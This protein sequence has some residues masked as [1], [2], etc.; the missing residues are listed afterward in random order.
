M[1]AIAF[2]KVFLSIAHN[3]QIPI[4]FTEAE[5]GEPYNKANSPKPFECLSVLLN[6]SLIII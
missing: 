6:S 3:P 4:A 2:L 1:S 5:R